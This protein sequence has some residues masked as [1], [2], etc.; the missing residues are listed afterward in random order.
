[1]WIRILKPRP[2]VRWRV[3]GWVVA[4]VVGLPAAADEV[5][6]LADFPALTEHSAVL[7]GS[8]TTNAQVFLRWGRG[9]GGPDL[10]QWERTDALGLRPAGRFTA[11]LTRLETFRNYFFAF[12]AVRS[13]QEHWSAVASLRPQL[14]GML[15]RTGFE[16]NE[17]FPFSPGTLDGQGGPVTWRLRDGS[18]VV[19][20]GVAAH[21]GQAVHAGPGS[22]ELSLTATNAV[23]WIDSFHLDTGSTNAPR[24]PTEPASSVVFFSATRGL[25]ALD[26]DGEGGGFFVQ[27]MPAWPTN[28]FVRVSIRNDYPARRYDLWID[29]V[30]R[31]TD[32]GFKDNS[33]RGFSGVSRRTAETSYLDDF[34]VSTW[35]LDADS[36]SDGLNDLDEAKFYGTCPLLADSDGDGMNDGDEVLAG[37]DPN[38]P[39]SCFAIRM[40]LDESGQP[41]V[42]IPT[43]AGRR[44]SL[45]RSDAPG[46]GQWEDV[47]GATN[48]AGDGTEKTF[49]D[50]NGAPRFFYRGIVARP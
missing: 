3:A 31:R 44:Y 11:T 26:G 46:T 8:L 6:S 48:L 1:M 5:V 10:I 34:S 17:M 4:A 49:T 18:A 24:L 36:D 45:Q 25:L 12:G 50:T 40:D 29:G 47:P 14:Q 42:T 41:R 35:G 23:L 21:G 2:T 43:V 37:T 39:T 28:R 20:P 9:N 30:Q 15:Y 27:V 38:D 13:G 19:Q 33:V 16:A 32:L 7:A 22:M